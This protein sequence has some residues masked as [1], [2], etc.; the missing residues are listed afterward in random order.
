MARKIAV[1]LD[2]KS[3]TE[4]DRRSRLDHELKKLDRVEEQRLAEE[5]IGD[6]SWPRS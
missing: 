1:T 4:R 6:P 5:G 3:V 2:A